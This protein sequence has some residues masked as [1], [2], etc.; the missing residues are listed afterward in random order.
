MCEQVTVM[1]RVLIYGAG[2]AGEMVLEEI[3]KRPQENIDVQG[4]MDDDEA[5]LGTSIA[6]TGR[7]KESP[8]SYTQ[9]CH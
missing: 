1:R 5:K 7:Q 3:S 9:S 6:R 4:F 2:E 8:E